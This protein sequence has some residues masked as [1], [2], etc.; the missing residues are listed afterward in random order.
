LS[1]GSADSFSGDSLRRSWL[2]TFH[3]PTG[4]VGGRALSRAG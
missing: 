4:S 2:A 1:D 3:A